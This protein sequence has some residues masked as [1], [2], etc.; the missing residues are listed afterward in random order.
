MANVVK[1]VI[2]WEIDMENSVIEPK[3]DCNELDRYYMSMPDGY[4]VGTVGAGDSFCAGILYS[5]YKK[6]SMDE[7]LKIA[8][9]SA[10]A[11]LSAGDSVGGLRSIEE[12]M[13]L[14]DAYSPR[15]QW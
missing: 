1:A 13:K 7:A 14:Y 9:A 3:L 11:N 5:I 15:K 12:T 10:A 6:L 2:K 4:I 8:A